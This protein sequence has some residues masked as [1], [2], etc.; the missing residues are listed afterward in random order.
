MPNLYISWINFNGDVSKINA[1][2]EF[3]NFTLHDYIKNNQLEKRIL[4]AS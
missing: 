4:N 1:E 2:S 3:L